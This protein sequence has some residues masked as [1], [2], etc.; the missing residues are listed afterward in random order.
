MIKCK[1]YF[2]IT[3]AL[4][5]VKTSPLTKLSSLGSF[6]V[7]SYSARACNVLLD[8]GGDDVFDKT[9][10]E[11]CGDKCV[12]EVLTLLVCLTSGGESGRGAA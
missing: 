12:G 2:H 3:L 7:K 11:V 6:A 5:K 9:R 1:K 8:L 10:G 4:S